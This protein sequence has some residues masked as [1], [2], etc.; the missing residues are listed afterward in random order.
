MGAW[1]LV[2]PHNGVWSAMAA[3]K[4][5]K[6]WTRVYTNKLGRGGETSAAI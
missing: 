1:Y 3:E 6:S 5:G 2:W 4:Q